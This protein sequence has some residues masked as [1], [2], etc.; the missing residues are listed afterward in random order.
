MSEM[1]EV[2]ELTLEELRAEIAEIDHELVELIARRTYIAET[3]AS[4]KQ[5]QDLPTTDRDQE[6]RVTTRAAELAD[7]F[8]LDP[9]VVRRVFEE[10]IELNKSSQ[11]RRRDDD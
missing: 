6:G 1:P 9:E 5:Q 10:L 4:V 8:Q 11:R 7:R 3:I 2:D